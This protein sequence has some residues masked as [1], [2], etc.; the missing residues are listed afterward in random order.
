MR[1]LKFND[2]KKNIE[3]EIMHIT[4]FKK[5]KFD[6]HKYLKVMMFLLILMKYIDQGSA[7]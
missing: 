4:L 6:L 1:Q 2:D 3:L 7:G 5:F